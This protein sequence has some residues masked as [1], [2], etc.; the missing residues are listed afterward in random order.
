[1][2]YYTDKTTSIV[3]SPNYNIVSRKWSTDYQY[4][5]QNPFEQDELRNVEIK[6]RL[7]LLEELEKINVNYTYILNEYSNIKNEIDS[8]SIPRSTTNNIFIDTNKSL[9]SNNE[10]IKT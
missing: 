10:K 2:L 8:K 9:N 6:N 7:S 5:I 4:W 3:K 1:M